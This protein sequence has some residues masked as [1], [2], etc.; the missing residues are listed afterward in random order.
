MANVDRGPTLV[1]GFGNELCGDD[2]IGPHVAR[3][4]EARRLPNVRVRTLHQLTPELAEEI[5]SASQVVFVDASRELRPTAVV[6]A[7][8]NLEETNSLQTHWV[9]PAG[10]LALTRAIYGRMPRAWL[11][12]VE[13]KHFEP[14]DRVS[15]STIAHAEEAV[16][17]IIALLT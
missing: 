1:I 8:V 16:Q 2:G 14:G 17:R 11:V 3:V 10:V 15:P 9:D 12:T 7:P 13:G 6:V 4:I 5:H